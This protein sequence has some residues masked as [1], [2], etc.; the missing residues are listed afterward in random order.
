MH[1]ITVLITGLL[2]AVS[3][4]RCR[5]GSNDVLR[6]INHNGN[7][8]KDTIRHV[9]AQENIFDKRID[10]TVCLLCQELVVSILGKFLRVGGVRVRLLND[11]NEVLIEVNL[12]DMRDMCR[13]QAGNGAI[14]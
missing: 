12:T 13:V 9:I 7:P 2:P 11:G 14:G 5:R 10:T 6:S 4:I 3:R 1:E 8:R